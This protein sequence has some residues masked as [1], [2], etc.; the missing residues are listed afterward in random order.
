MNAGG[1]Y[2]RD[3]AAGKPWYV[4]KNEVRDRKVQGSLYKEALTNRKRTNR[5]LALIDFGSFSS[6][7]FKRPGLSVLIFYWPEKSA[8]TPRNRSRIAATAARTDRWL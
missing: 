4:A 5:L 2:L 8:H 3:P 1:I 6:D 7:P